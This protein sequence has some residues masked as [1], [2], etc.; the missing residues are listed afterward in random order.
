MDYLAGGRTTGKVIEEQG[1]APREIPTPADPL[2]L[3]EEEIAQYQP[4]DFPELPPFT[5]G[6]VGYLSY[7]YICRVE[8]TVSRAKTN[9][10]GYCILLASE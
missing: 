6:A 7:E 9:C 8:D 2:S 1:A 3:I 5:G 10:H 4:I